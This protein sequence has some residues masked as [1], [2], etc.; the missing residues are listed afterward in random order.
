MH[1]YIMLRY[2]WAG[3]FTLLNQLHRGMQWLGTSG[4]LM[5]ILPSGTQQM[6]GHYKQNYCSYHFKDGVYHVAISQ[7]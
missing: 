1:A 7:V 5:E 4:E 6:L 2:I 3:V